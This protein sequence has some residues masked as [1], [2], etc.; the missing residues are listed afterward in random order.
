MY[1]SHCL[2]SLHWANRLLLSF[3]LVLPFI[4]QA[5]SATDHALTL[6]VLT[7]EPQLPAGLTMQDVAPP[8]IALPAAPAGAPNILVILLDDVGFAA[9][10]TFGGLA[11]TPTLE[12]LAQQGLRY[13]RFHTTGICSPTRASLLT[14]RNPHAVGVGAVLNSASS[15]PGYRGMLHPS[16]VT[17]AEIL[18]Q[19]GYAT[20]AWGKWHLAPD[21]EISPAGPFKR[22]PTGVGFDTFY[23]F[24]GGETHQYEPTLYQG[25]TQV[26]RPRRPDYHLTED[27]T[28]RAIAWMRQHHALRPQQPF[29]VYFAPGATH[30]PLHVPK[31]WIERYKGRFDH[32]WDQY[33]DEG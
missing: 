2:R 25:N 16:T 29:F 20:S 15:Y 31:A 33:R 22:W 12:H 11:Q 19:H 8:G 32:G 24:L 21:W 23:G 7:P 6:P 5:Q 17:I 30:A 27:I 13:N 3:L 26:R 10:S 9:S 18:R 28:E 4:A 1:S 14:G